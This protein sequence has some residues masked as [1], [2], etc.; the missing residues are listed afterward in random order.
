MTHRA[1]YLLSNPLLFLLNSVINM[2]GGV[3]Q[4]KITGTAIVNEG[5]VTFRNPKIVL[6]LAEP[7]GGNQAL[8]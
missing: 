8:I 2:K 7:L 4:C 1:L 6:R 5:S 3:V